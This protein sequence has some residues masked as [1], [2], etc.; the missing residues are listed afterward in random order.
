MS[1]APVSAGA[2]AAVVVAGAFVSPFFADARAR[3]TFTTTGARC[4]AK[5]L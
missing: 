3:N 5:T 1:A 2:A 4:S